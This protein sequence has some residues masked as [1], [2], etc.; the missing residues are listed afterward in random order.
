M[1]NAPHRATRSL[2]CARL[3]I[4][5]F[6]KSLIAL[7]PLCLSFSCD[8]GFPGWPLAHDRLDLIDPVAD[9]IEEVWNGSECRHCGRTEYCPVPLE[10]P[11]L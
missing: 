7:F 10:E 8:P 3:L 9:M 2:P 4:A 6:P 5:M 11:R 1:T